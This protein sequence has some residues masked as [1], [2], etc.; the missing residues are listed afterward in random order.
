MPVSNRFGVLHLEWQLCV[1]GIPDR[2]RKQYLV[3]LHGVASQDIGV[4]KF[5]STF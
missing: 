1:Y 2:F 5:P 3:G 4:V